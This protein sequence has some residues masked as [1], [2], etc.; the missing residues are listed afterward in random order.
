MSEVLDAL[1]DWKRAAARL[2]GGVALVCEKQIESEL[3]QLDT[4]AAR[5]FPATCRGND[6]RNRYRLW[7]QRVMLVLAKGLSLYRRQAYPQ[8]KKL[9]ALAEDFLNNCLGKVSEQPSTGRGTEQTFKCSGTR[10]RLHYFQGLLL[11]RQRKF[12][13]ATA[14]F[15]RSM[16]FCFDRLDE[17]LRL[18][19]RPDSGEAGQPSRH[20]VERS[21][22]TYCLAKLL[23][24]LGET[25]YRQ[26]RLHTARR[27]LL[28][29]RVLLKVSADHFLG[30]RA[31]LL[32]CMIDR[33]DESIAHQG[34]PLLARFA[35][36]HE[37]LKNHR[38]YGI[39]ASMEEIITSVYLHHAREKGQRIIRGRG[40]RMGLDFEAAL[41]RIAD[42]IK[43]ID[44]L[45]ETMFHALLV[46]ARIQTRLKKWDEV[47]KSVEQAEEALESVRPAAVR[48][49]LAAE[50]KVVLARK[51]LRKGN[52]GDALELFR[53][54]LRL[55]HESYVFQFS[56][57]LHVFEILLN[58]D[59]LTEAAARI[60]PCIELLPNVDSA[61]Q[62]A[63]FE[64]LRASLES[65]AECT[66][67]FDPDFKLDHGRTKLDC[68]YVKYLA[69][70]IDKKPS[71]ILEG[72]NWKILVEQHHVNPGQR[73]VIEKVVRANFPGYPRA[74]IRHDRRHTRKSRQVI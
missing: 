34:W 37:G 39:E 33:E 3:E 56:C 53:E 58:M 18:D 22:A 21:F 2:V 5:E 15:D 50:V 1:G 14:E 73:Q 70:L 27:Q 19:D 11:M 6:R 43:R 16:T 25:A 31:E 20:E 47:N 62:R 48:L 51:E 29:A 42:D 36:C 10:C 12:D 9:L 69:G 55:Q 13:D 67:H 63:R 40:P 68:H 4:F 28:S 17:Q 66:L 45:P 52:P 24:H 74:G 57:H 41:T 59:N 72:H 7:R 44:N 54:A 26:G 8:A 38:I 32:L 30:H 61:F 65:R 60:A 64:K 46:R 49:P 35:A 23:V 71:E